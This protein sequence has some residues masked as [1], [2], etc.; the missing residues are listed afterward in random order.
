MV[1]VPARTLYIVER[2]CP[3]AKKALVDFGVLLFR[4]RL[5]DHRKVLHVVAWR[6]LMA[7]S[8]ILGGGRWMGVPRYTPRR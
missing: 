5:R 7:L 2:V 8:A 3:M 1:L 4:N 6:R